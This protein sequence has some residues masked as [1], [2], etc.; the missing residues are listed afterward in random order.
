[1]HKL[2]KSEEDEEEEA[3]MS[4]QGRSLCRGHQNATDDAGKI[5][6]EYDSGM[7]RDNRKEGRKDAADGGGG[8]GGDTEELLPPPPAATAPPLTP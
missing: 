1:M 6:T 7:G 2:P 8:G 4:S 5:Q 3:P